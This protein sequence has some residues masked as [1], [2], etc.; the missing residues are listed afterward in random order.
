MRASDAKA[1]TGRR[2]VVRTKDGMAYG[3]GGT[4]TAGGVKANQLVLTRKGFTAYEL[5]VGSI[6]SIVTFGETAR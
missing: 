4:L 5:P 1:V 6:E 3:S 2:V